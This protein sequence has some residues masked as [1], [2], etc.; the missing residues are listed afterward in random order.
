MGMYALNMMDIAIEIAMHDKTF[1]DSATKFFEHFVMIAEALNELGLWCPDDRF[2]YDTL[3]R[4]DSPSI[5]MRIQSV[6]G[7]TSYL[8]FPSLIKKQ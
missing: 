3:C 6:V 8:P 1:E 7:L 4:P 2:F 5:M